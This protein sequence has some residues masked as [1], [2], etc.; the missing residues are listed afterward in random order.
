MVVE[1]LLG[2][3]TLSV[4]EVKEAG[5][6]NINILI[7]GL[8]ISG[9]NG[10]S[11]I[12][13]ED[14]DI[15]LKAAADL[16]NIFYVNDRSERIRKGQEAVR[17]SKISGKDAAI[18]LG[19]DIKII[20][21]LIKQ[22]NLPAIRWGRGYLIDPEVLDRFIKENTELIK[23]MVPF[24]NLESEEL[25][26][27]FNNQV[28]SPQVKTFK[29]DNFVSTGGHSS[30]LKSVTGLKHVMLKSM[31][32]GCKEEDVAYALGL[33]SQE[34]RLLVASGKI[35]Q[36]D[37]GIVDDQKNKLLDN[38]SVKEFA[39]KRKDIIINFENRKGALKVFKTFLK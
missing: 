5:V 24:Y 34:L 17:G 9:N 19:C 30:I 20:F 23:S 14:I 12:T 38:D 39:F 27:I 35:K 31:D 2:R 36:I 33:G 32:N 6:P 26:E 29:E 1:S 37:N 28:V 13:K 3:E 15:F 8:P 21:E 7:K 16:K 10:N 25:K 22:H 18:R 11:Y 4:E